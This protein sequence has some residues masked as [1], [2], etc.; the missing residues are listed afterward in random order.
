MSDP[1]ESVQSSADSPRGMGRFLRFSLIYGIGDLLT[2]GARIILLPFYMAV[3]SAAELGELYVLQA[4]SFICW[5]LL[6]FGLHFAVQKFYVE[7]KEL[8][9]IHI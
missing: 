4:I 8:S 6:G 5:T 7:Y 1:Q 2:K 9:L 3:L